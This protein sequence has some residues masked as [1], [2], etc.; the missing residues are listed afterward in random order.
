MI[1]CKPFD[2]GIFVDFNCSTGIAM[3]SDS[4]NDQ[5]GN[6]HVVE[7]NAVAIYSKDNKLMLQIGLKIWDLSSDSVELSY[8]HNI[9]KR[10]SCFQVLFNGE[11][12]SIE[13]EAWWAKI[14]MF[15]PV[16][17]EMDEDEDFMAYIL[18]VWKNAQLQK[19]LLSRWS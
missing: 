9:S 2:M 16:E 18:S 19:T 4:A 8:F 5:K 13:Y 14:P 3:P 17:P 11:L 10:T 6:F 12:T 7:G 1:L 15:V